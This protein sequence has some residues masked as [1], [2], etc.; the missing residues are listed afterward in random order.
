MKKYIFLILSCLFLTGCWGSL[1]SNNKV[2]DSQDSLKN[3][4]VKIEKTESLISENED[5]KNE[6]TSIYAAGV[7]YSLSKIDNPSQEVKTAT[8]LN[9][10]IISITGTPDLEEAEKIKKI[11]DL[12]NSEVQA[13]RIKGEYLLRKKDQEI[14][15]L[16]IENKRLKEKYDVQAQ[17]FIKKSEKIAVKSDQNE[18]IIDDL[19]GYFGLK[20]VFWGLKKFFLSG[21]T[22]ILIFSIIFIILKILSRSHPIPAAIFSIFN[23]IGSLFLAMVK[24]LTPKSFELSKYAPA[25]TLNI[26]K[27]TLNKIVDVIQDLKNDKKKNPSK[28]YSLDQVLALFNGE[29]DQ[30]EKDLIERMLKELNWKK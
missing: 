16:Q 26:Y 22:A 17:E 6:Q 9:D 30:Q 8:K 10:R 5:L 20:A 15:L 18:G 2:T 24:A 14:I 4:K 27:S 21:L 25:E 28:T 1:N 3:Q 13:E 11:V 12:L 29:M 23:V 19:G 7:Q